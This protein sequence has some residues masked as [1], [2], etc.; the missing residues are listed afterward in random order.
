MASPYIPPKD[1]DLLAWGANF[2]DLITAD[3]ATYQL[4][5]ADALT[6]Q[7]AYDNYAAAQ[8]LVDNPGTKTSVTVAS[9]NSL[10]QV[11]IGIARTYSSQIRINAGITNEAKLDLGLNL[12]NNSPSP[13]PAPTSSPIITVVGTTPG[14]ATIRYADSNTPSSRAKPQ[15]VLQLELYVGA[16]TTTLGPPPA[17]PLYGLVTRQPFAV[18]F[19][20]EDAGKTATMYSRWTTRTGLTGPWSAAVTCVIPST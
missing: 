9:K 5:T 3:P 17:T 10:K 16:S 11:F 6:I 18:M 4:T 14:S 13:I 1:A 8:A 19:D 12:P 15:G 2:S 7:T 20:A